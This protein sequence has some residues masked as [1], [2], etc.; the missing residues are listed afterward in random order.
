MDRPVARS[1]R[2]LEELSTNAFLYPFGWVDEGY[3]DFR[4][5][6]IRDAL[7]RTVPAERAA[8]APR[9]GRRV[10]RAARGRLRDPRLGPLRARRACAPRP[11]ERRWP[12]PREASAALEPGARRSSCTA[13]AVANMPDDSPRPSVREL[14]EPTPSR[15]SRSTTCRSATRRRAR[16][17]RRLPRGRAAGRGGRRARTRRRD[18]PARGASAGGASALLARPR[19]SC[20]R[21]PDDPERNGVA[22]RRPSVPGLSSISTVSASTAALAQFDEARRLRGRASDDPDIG[23][24]DYVAWPRLADACGATSRPAW[25][26]MRRIAREARAARLE[27]TGVTAY[28]GRR[29]SRPRHGLP[30]P[31]SWHGR[32]PALRRRDRA[33]VLPPRDAATSAHVA[34]AAGRWD[35]AIALAE[36]ELVEKGSRRRHAR[37]AGRARVRRARPRRG[38]PR[39]ALLEDSLAIGRAER[40]GRAHPAAAVGPG[41]DRSA[42]RRREPGVALVRE[43]AFDRARHAGERA[44]LVPFVVTGVRA[45]FQAGRPPDAAERWLDTSATPPGSRTS[46]RAALD[47]GRRAGPPRGRARRCRPRDASRRRSP[48]GTRTARSGRRRGRGSTWRTCLIRANRYAEAVPILNDGARAAE[49]LGSAPLARR[50]DDAAADR[51]RAA[52]RSTSRGGR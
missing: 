23:D 47:H 19:R 5:Q 9:P 14:Y 36:I 17:P 28:R 1:G 30:R 12:A 37:L 22:V 32:G 15:R 18:G 41:G 10:R 16:A 11:I 40:R 34:W 33:V 20:D 31:R 7:Y 39:A 26:A 21:C 52:A 2:P 25:H 4:H 50:A 35:E 8:A 3:Y 46:A 49:R 38:R 29:R 6:L 43:A 44:L 27:S 48:A 45:A 42:G 13:R 51:A 24:I